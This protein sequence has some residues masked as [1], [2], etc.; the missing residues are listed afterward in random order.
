MSFGI[1]TGKESANRVTVLYMKSTKPGMVQ[2]QY[3]DAA[4]EWAVEDLL[5]LGCLLLCFQIFLYTPT[6]SR[7]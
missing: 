6:M 5:G 2:G 1:G 4:V 3:E 7:L